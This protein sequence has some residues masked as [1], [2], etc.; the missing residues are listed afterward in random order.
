M[1]KIFSIILTALLLTAALSACSSGQPASVQNTAPA[2]ANQAAEQ[3]DAAPAEDP[4]GDLKKVTVILDYMPNTNHTG[5]YV[6]KDKGYYAQ[7]GLDV[8]I[9][10]PTEGATNTLIAQNIG[11]FGIT[12]QEDLTLALT[13]E[14][15]LPL[16]AIA[17]LI[18]HNTSGFVTLADSGINSPADWEGKTYA[19]WG[20]SGENAVIHAVMDQAGADF[21]KLNMVISDGL[22]FESLGKSCDLMWFF[23]AWDSVQA[24]MAGVKLNYIPCKELDERLDYYTP[25][26]VANTATL[27]SD[28]GLVKAFLS[29][30][31]KG[32]KD[33]I[34]DPEAA[35]ETLYKFAPDYDLEMLKI[36]QKYLADKFIDDAPAWGYMKDE[37]WDNYTNFMLE[38][39]VIE[40]PIVAADCYTNEFLPTEDLPV[41]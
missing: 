39:D 20:G 11:T 38:Y 36:S 24:E 15:P 10:E 30:T 8:E 34:A 32:Y 5:M 9:I 23:E 35:A 4:A 33:C 22:G 18:Q 13:A 3:A 7:E 37:P 28:P 21:S 2:E 16:K 1:K 19:G 40:S 31:E 29:A 17:T 27:E 26:I 6:A 14:D 25:I 41:K 12:Y